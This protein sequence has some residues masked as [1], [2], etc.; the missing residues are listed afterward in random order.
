MAEKLAISADELIKAIEQAFDGVECS[1]TSLRQ[2]SLTEQFGLLR[3][4]TDKE[5]TQAGKSRIDSKWQDIPDSEIEECNCLLAFMQAKEFKYF[6]PAYMRYSV[7]NYKK[8]IWET[9]IIGG[10][11][12]SLFPSSKNDDLYVYNV[13]QLSLLIE[14]QKSTVVQFLHFVATS[15]GDVQRPDAVKALERYWYKN[16]AT[17]L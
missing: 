13:R 6:L 7:N 16:S 3:D 8:S 10:V 17:Q 15:A 4:I 14:T 1:T 5:W 12:H 9:D 2:F 11:V